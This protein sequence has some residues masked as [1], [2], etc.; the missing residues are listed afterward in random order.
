MAAD[1]PRPHRPSVAPRRQHRARRWSYR[2]RVRNP[3][4]AIRCPNHTLRMTDLAKALG[5][6]ASLG[7]HVSLIILRS[8]DYWPK[9][10]VPPLHAAPAHELDQ[11]GMAKL[12]HARLVNIQIVRSRF[13]DHVDSLSM[14]PLVDTFSAVAHRTRGQLA[15][16]HEI[17]ILGAPVPQLLREA[18]YLNS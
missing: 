9:L 1:H 5:L 2:K 11:R 6:S 10:P 4:E 15:S 3:R 18:S 8:A 13:L 14:G 12:K 16:N 7:H 17:D